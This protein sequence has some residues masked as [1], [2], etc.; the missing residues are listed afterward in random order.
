[1]IQDAELPNNK[2]YST[3]IV[4][5]FKFRVPWKKT[6]EL[7]LNS[8]RM[9]YINQFYEIMA[10]I[11]SPLSLM[12]KIVMATIRIIPTIRRVKMM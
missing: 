12:T 6:K 1:M 5:V 8:N 10:R 11:S 9:I 7:D 3:H 2:I 4:V